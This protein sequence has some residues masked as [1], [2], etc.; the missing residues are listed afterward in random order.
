MR[1][2]LAE[3]PV[4]H[5]LGKHNV[6]RLQITENEIGLAEEASTKSQR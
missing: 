1:A 5:R 3:L 2:G 4:L 6:L